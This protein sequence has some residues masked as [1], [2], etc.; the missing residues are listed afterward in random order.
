MEK[1]EKTCATCNHV[2]KN[3]DGSCECGCKVGVTV[4]AEKD[5]K[6]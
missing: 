5:G 4:E 1:D 6:V 3:A 2:H